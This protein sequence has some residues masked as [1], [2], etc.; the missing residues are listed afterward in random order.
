MASTFAA[1]ARSFDGWIEGPASL[2]SE[3]WRAMRRGGRI[4]VH[5]GAD[6]SLRIPAGSKDTAALMIVPTGALDPAAANRLSAMLVGRQVGLLMP[7]A[8]VIERRLELPPE[9][10]AHLDGIVA[11][12]IG[13]LSPLPP[14]DVLFGHKVLNVDRA[15]RKMEAG[16]AIVPRARLAAAIEAIEGAGVREVTVEAPL[17]D[18]S[19]VLLLPARSGRGRGHGPAKIA[20][21]LLLLLALIAGLGALVARPLLDGAGQERRAGIEARAEA[22]RRIISA[23]S[24]PA[25]AVTGPEQGALRL[26]SDAVSA[27]GALD[28][29]AAALPLHSHATE[30]LLA[31]GKIRLSGVTSDLPDVLTKLESSGRF[32]ESRLVGSAITSEDGVTSE[33]VLETRPLIRTGGELK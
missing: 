11:S 16:I 26:K 14:Q 10:A 4:D 22:A 24:A 21:T 2:V 13:S 20:L 27:L 28:D 6:G 30:I 33:F 9:A 29:L 25:D 17:S 5:L 31:D 19:R 12:R 32:A 18:G 23:A 3:C 1:A 15:G 8:W 7:S